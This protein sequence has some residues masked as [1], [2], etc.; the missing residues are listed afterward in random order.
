[1]G[2]GADLFQHVESPDH[3]GIEFAGEF[4]VGYRASFSPS[5]KPRRSTENT[6]PRL[7]V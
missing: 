3:V 6:T 5:R 2:I 4:F 1:M 7:L